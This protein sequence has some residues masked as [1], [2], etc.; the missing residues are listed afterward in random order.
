M[1]FLELP[2]RGVRQ[3]PRVAWRTLQLFTQFKADEEAV[4]NFQ[5]R[6]LAGWEMYIQLGS[7]NS[8]TLLRSYQVFVLISEY[9]R[10]H[11]WF[12]NW[13][14]PH[15]ITSLKTWLSDVLLTSSTLLS[16]EY[17]YGLYRSFVNIAVGRLSNWLVLLPGLT[18]SNS[19]CI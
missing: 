15:L 17:F 8:W 12:D 13:S 1:K 4:G 3:Q 6:F 9:L 2:G 19:L 7:G 5:C 10:L 18:F 11:M 16:P 14:I